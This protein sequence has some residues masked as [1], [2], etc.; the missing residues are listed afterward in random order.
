MK[1]CCVR[2]LVGSAAVL[3]LLGTTGCGGLL[4]KPP[5]APTFYTL[6]DAPRADAS[7]TR[8]PLPTMGPRPTLA[9]RFSQAAAGHDSTRI[10]YT[11][12][13]Q[14]LDTYANSVWIDTP[15][16]M[17]TPMMVAAIESAGIFPAVVGTPSAAR[18]DIELDTQILRLQ[19]DFSVTP[20]R[21]RFTLRASLIDSASRVVLASDQFDAVADSASED[22]RGGV[23]AAHVAVRSVLTRLV[24]LCSDAEARWKAANNEKQAERNS[25]RP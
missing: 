18:A 21:V 11:R 12:G 13:A 2:S 3:L 22:A 7:T 1:P 23:L 8:R 17:L 19:Q 9:V 10:V 16:Q 6:D 20:S 24:T 15:A 25:A 4:P 14:R 5:V